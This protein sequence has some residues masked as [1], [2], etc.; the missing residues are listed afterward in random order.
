MSFQHIDYK[1]VFRKA[2]NRK[3]DALFEVKPELNPVV[4]CAFNPSE[5]CDLCAYIK[6]CQIK[7]DGWFI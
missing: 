4:H 1:Q 5:G 7:E 3:F 2:K 6:R